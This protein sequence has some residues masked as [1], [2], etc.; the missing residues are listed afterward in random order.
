MEI[1]EV[2][3]SGFDEGPAQASPAPAASEVPNPGRCF[4]F[5]LLDGAGHW[6]QEEQPEQVTALM[7]DFLK[8]IRRIRRV[9]AWN[10]REPGPFAPVFSDQNRLRQKY[11]FRSS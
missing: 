6:V 1:E 4:G 2:R 3:W 11:P 8:V 7:I 10:Q 5:H 9:C